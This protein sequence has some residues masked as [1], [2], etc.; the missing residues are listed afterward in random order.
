MLQE[1]KQIHPLPQKLEESLMKNI[2]PGKR[3][4]PGA[5]NR[6]FDVSTGDI[7]DIMD[8]LNKRDIVRLR[9]QVRINNETRDTVYKLKDLPTTYYDEESDQEI[10]L[11]SENYVPVYEVAKCQIK[12]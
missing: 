1:V 2:V 10:E 3:I 9:F 12:N 6:R 5:Y 7:V 4:Y 11:S 8:R